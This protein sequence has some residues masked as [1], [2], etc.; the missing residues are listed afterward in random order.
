MAEDDYYERT[1]NKHCDDIISQMKDREGIT[2]DQISNAIRTA[3]PFGDRRGKPY[4][5]FI[6]VVL[7]REAQLQKELATKSV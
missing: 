7:R 3:Y 2:F 5:K 1:T 4:K 6:K